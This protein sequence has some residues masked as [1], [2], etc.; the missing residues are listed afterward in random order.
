MKKIISILCLFLI[1][2]VVFVSGCTENNTTNTTAQQVKQTQYFEVM[3]NVTDLSETGFNI[4]VRKTTDKPI[5]FYYTPYKNGIPETGS[6]CVVPQG[7]D[8][9]KTF[10]L[11]VFDPNMLEYDAVDIR[12][13]EDE[14][15]QNTLQKE[16]ITLK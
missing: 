3:G 6:W 16:H 4:P 10:M 13:C 7:I 12:A 11:G 15:G 14:Y 2:V 1:A 9:T 5:Y 8:T